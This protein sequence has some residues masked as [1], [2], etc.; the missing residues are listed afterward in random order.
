[1][2]AARFARLGCARA[3]DARTKLLYG[4]DGLGT[5]VACLESQRTE[6]TMSFGLNFNVVAQDAPL[7]H[8]RGGKDHSMEV[9]AGVVPRVEGQPFCVPGPMGEALLFDGIRDA[10]WFDFGAD[11]RLFPEDGPIAIACWFRTSSQ[12]GRHVL[13]SS[14]LVGEGNDGLWLGFDGSAL[15]F[16]VGLDPDIT[17]RACRRDLVGGAWHHVVA[18]WDGEQAQLWVDG[19]LHGLN[20]A[21][22]RLEYPNRASL[23]IGATET[24]YS[25]SDRWDGGIGDLRVYQCMLQPEVIRLLAA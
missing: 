16:S 15:K 9:L 23:G 13:L 22:G 18:C 7:V 6:A 8:L 21:S 25:G 1:V 20:G 5:S 14:R 12:R 17:L 24:S 3:D 2:E 4:G 19:E 10:L 11:Q